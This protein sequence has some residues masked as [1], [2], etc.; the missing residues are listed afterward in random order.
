MIRVED[1]KT[2]ALP[3][4]ENGLAIYLPPFY[5]SEVGAARRLNEIFSAPR[6]VEVDSDGLPD[7]IS[8]ATNMTYDPVQMDAITTAVQSKVLILTGGPGTGKT[9]TTLG[10]ITAFRSAGANILPAPATFSGISS[11]AA[12]TR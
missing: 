3:D 12:P 1:V 2:E 9:T 7:R 10:I 6:T 8:Q 5:F 11:T 4:A